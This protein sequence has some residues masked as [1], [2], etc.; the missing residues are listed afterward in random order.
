[1]KFKYSKPSGDIA[2]EVDDFRCRDHDILQRQKTLSIHLQTQD[3]RQSCL[4]CLNSI[5]SGHSFIHRNVD[6]V[7]CAICGHV[8]TYCQSP[9]GYPNSIDGQGFETIYPKLTQ[10]EYISRK[11]RIYKPKLDWILKALADNGIEP[12][13]ALQQKWMELG[14]GAG[15]FLHALKEHG[16][17]NITGVDATP[18]LVKI[19]N[20][21]LGEPIAKYNSDDMATLILSSD[22][23]IYVSFFVLEHLD[24]PQ[25][26]WEALMDKPK[27]TH[28]IFSVPMFGLSTILESRM[29]DYAARNLDSAVHT[30]LYTDKSIKFVLNKYGYTGLNQWVFGQDAVDFVRMIA[31]GLDEKYSDNI[32]D[33]VIESLNPLVDDFQHILDKAFLADARHIIAVKS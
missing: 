2:K 22:A 10:N 25:S 9:E 3:R 7:K 6:Y 14:C 28:F 15:Y 17:K 16:A 31:V 24:N 20:E 8:Q 5:E 21:Y 23:D 27:G 33:E 4:L 12:S 1:M 32:Y 29:D 13:K 26:V 30:Q 11:D 18:E 19:A